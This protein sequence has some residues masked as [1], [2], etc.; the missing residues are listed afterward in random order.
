[1]LPR[2]LRRSQLVLLLLSVLLTVAAAAAHPSE[3]DADAPL[4][5]SR[6]SASPAPLAILSSTSIPAR[7]LPLR[8]LAVALQRR[9]W[10]VE[11]IVYEWCMHEPKLKH[12]ADLQTIPGITLRRIDANGTAVHRRMLE[13]RGLISEQAGP[14]TYLPLYADW[15]RVHAIDMALEVDA[16]LAAF[17]PEEKANT[18]VVADMDQIG[19]AFAGIKHNVTSVMFAPN[20]FSGLDRHDCRYGSWFDFVCAV[21]GVRLPMTPIQHLMNGAINMVLAGLDRFVLTHARETLTAQA[22]G[23]PAGHEVYDYAPCKKPLMPVLAGALPGLGAPLHAVSP[24][25]QL[26]GPFLEAESL[27]P[28]GADL[29]AWLDDHQRLS[30]QVLYVC[31]GTSVVLAEHHIVRIVVAMQHILSEHPEIDILWS[32]PADPRK[33]LV[34]NAV[35]DEIKSSNAG[36]SER[37]RLEIFT[38]QK[39]VLA[40]PAVRGFVTQCGSN[41]CLEGLF[42]GVPIVGMGFP[43]LDQ[44]HNAMRVDEFGAGIALP[45][46]TEPTAEDIAKAWTRVLTDPILSRRARDASHIMRRAGGVEKAVDFLDDLRAVGWKHLVPTIHQAHWS[47]KYN[48]DIGLLWMIFVSAPIVLAF[49]ALWRRSRIVASALLVGVLAFTMASP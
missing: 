49:A 32:L 8:E 41:S 2:T 19:S 12:V 16:R 5:T 21:N 39:S 15:I 36:G 44:E 1:M 46:S 29:Q 28:L 22:L 10:R 20:V 6:V 31:Y 48:V 18:I 4:P 38:A 25:V 17:T 37:I 14:T 7:M 13:L 47:V 43:H 23:F 45:W 35:W 27:A 33:L 30:R 11:W 9:G 42:F 3:T 24:W 40:H 26:M 34:G